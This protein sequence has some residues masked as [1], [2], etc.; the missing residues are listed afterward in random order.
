MIK[1]DD[2]CTS[3]LY[4]FDT[5][6]ANG[7]LMC[8]RHQRLNFKPLQS[9]NISNWRTLVSANLEPVTALAFLSDEKNL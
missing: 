4:S 7:E 8:A 1:G 9:S 5:V 3:S 2:Y 6:K